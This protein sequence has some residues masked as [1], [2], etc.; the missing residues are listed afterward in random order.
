MDECHAARP[1]QLEKCRLVAVVDHFRR[2]RSR[3][4]AT[5]DEYNLLHYFQYI[6][7]FVLYNH[8]R[9]GQKLWLV[10]GFQL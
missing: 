1:P 9:C 10:I 8:C 5:D 7:S 3:R 4:I 6:P 2:I